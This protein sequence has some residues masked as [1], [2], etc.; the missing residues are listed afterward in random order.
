MRNAHTHEEGMEIALDALLRCGVRASRD[1]LRARIREAFTPDLRGAAITPTDLRHE[2]ETL[3]VG[4]SDRQLGSSN[5][6]HRAWCEA[7]GKLAITASGD[8]TL[9]LWPLLPVVGSSQHVSTWA[10]AITGIT[11]DSA[12]AFRW[13]T[14]AEWK[15]LPVKTANH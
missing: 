9:K 11:Q 15:S 14:A 7:S 5:Q 3:L 2:I 4:L 10:E 13:M 6:L 1:M 8:G 12:G